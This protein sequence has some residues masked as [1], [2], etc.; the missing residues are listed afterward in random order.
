[1]LKVKECYST[2]DY[3]DVL[4]GKLFR[5]D[6]SEATWDHVMDTVRKKARQLVK[7]GNIQPKTFPW[8]L[9]TELEQEIDKL[10]GK[11]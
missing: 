2:R 7:S 11:G 6:V 10:M 8:Y 9:R 1:M 4:D 3:Q 5:G